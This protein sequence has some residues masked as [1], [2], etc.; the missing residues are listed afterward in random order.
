ME[1]KKLLET[2]EKDDSD[3]LFWNTWSCIYCSLDILLG[4]F[5]SSHT[6][7]EWN[8]IIS[9]PTFILQAFKPSSV[10]VRLVCS[11]VNI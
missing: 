2:L 9:F 1:K 3:Q 10:D 11:S 7:I 6:V 5:L 8:F 4:C